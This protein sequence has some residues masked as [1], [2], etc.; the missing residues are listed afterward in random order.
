[1]HSKTFRKSFTITSL[2]K[3]KELVNNGTKFSLVAW[4]TTGTGPKSQNGQ[5]QIFQLINFRA[6]KKSFYKTP[7]Y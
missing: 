4:V 2:I 7:A 6:L 1:M 3:I 5:F